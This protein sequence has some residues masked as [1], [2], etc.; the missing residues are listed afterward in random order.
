MSRGSLYFNRSR[1]SFLSLSGN[2]AFA[3]TTSTTPFTLEAWIFIYSTDG[4]IFSEQFTAA[5]NS[6]SLVCG[7]CDGTSIQNNGLYPAF[8]WYTGSA[9]VT[10]AAALDQITILTWT[11]VAFVFTGSTS[12][13]YINGLDR[14]KTSSPTPATTWGVVGVNGDTW[15]IGRKWDTTAGGTYWNG[16]IHDL[17][18]VKGSAVYTANFTPTSTG[19]SSIANTVLLT[20]NTYEPTILDSGPN[21]FTIINSNSVV[22]SRATPDRSSFLGEATVASTEYNSA[23]VEDN[24]KGRWSGLGIGP[25]Y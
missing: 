14:T 5:G 2:G 23:V 24:V 13:I 10:A 7:L 16:L 6:I 9:W 3:I 8:G 1:S 18:F 12:R 4:R 11:H 25:Q 17:R 22:T 19:L 20:C 15:Y 21:N